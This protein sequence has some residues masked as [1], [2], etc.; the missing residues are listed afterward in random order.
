[1][2]AQ[3]AESLRLAGRPWHAA[4]ALLAAAARE[5][6]LDPGFVLA[7]AKAELHAR[8]YD[9]ARGLLAGQ[10][11]LAGY[12]HGE[13][14]AGLAGGADP[15]RAGAAEAAAP[16]AAPARALADWGRGR[17]RRRMPPRPWGWGSGRSR[18]VPR[19]SAWHWRAR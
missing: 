8:R 16:G 9:R 17:R 14:L 2:A 1:M 12:A 11:W 4:E 3:Q 13:G 18:P 7:G 6:H 19:P 10:P 15:P 5:L